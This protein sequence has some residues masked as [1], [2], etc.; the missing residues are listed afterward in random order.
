KKAV[1]LGASTAEGIQASYWLGKMYGWQKDFTQ[2]D[3]AFRKSIDLAKQLGLTHDWAIY[4]T[5]W[6]Q[7]AIDQ[8]YANKNDAVALLA[9]CRQRAEPVLKEK[10]RDPLAAQII[11]RSYELEGKN[12]EAA[13]ACRRGLPE[14]I[15]DADESHLFLLIYRHNLE[16]FK[17]G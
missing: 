8:A 3:A 5:E 14:K 11:A 10:G 1:S 15:A 12:Q 4:R 7:L 17:T 16:L 6:A 13:T 9:E 2:A